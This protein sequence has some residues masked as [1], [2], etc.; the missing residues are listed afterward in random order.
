VT[1]T[2]IVLLAAAIFLVAAPASAAESDRL[3]DFQQTVDEVLRSYYEAGAG[4][5]FTESSRLAYG[6][7][8]TFAYYGTDDILSNTRL[9]GEIDAKFWLHAEA[10]GHEFYGR[11]R[12][13]Y[14]NF[15]EDDPLP[16]QKD[17]FTDPIFDRYWY[18]FDYRRDERAESG[19][20]PGW[21]WWVQAGRQYVEWLSGLALSDTLYA[22]RA[23][24]E[25]GSFTV[26]ALVALTPDS[27]VDFDGSRPGYDSDTSRFFWGFAAECR[28]LRR[29]R[30]Y[31]YFLAQDDHNDQPFPP[32]GPEYFYES[33]YVGVG[34]TGEIVT[35]TWLYRVE[36]VYEFGESIANLLGP[37][38]QPNDDIRAWAGRFYVAYMPAR[39]RET[40]GL[41]VEAEVLLG[42]GDDD[43]GAATT[44]AGGNTAGTS[45]R[46]F[47]AFGYV[48]TG[49][50]LA[51]ELANLIS[52]RVTGSAFPLRGRGAFDKMRVWISGFVFAKQDDGAPVSVATLP[53]EGYLGSEIDIGV[54]WILANDVALNLQYGIFL[55]GDAFADS[56][57]L[58]FFYV[59]ISY[60]F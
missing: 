40:L 38:P 10:R 15:D 3:R 22:A 1:V 33:R 45:D 5:T 37:L 9:F 56:D 31:V 44:T 48:N 29:H 51:P 28:A 25:R 19:F 24:L 35:G 54:D 8:T 34:S 23:G 41:R 47:I 39:A 13:L 7:Y 26:Q 20:D 58:H 32:G 14:D 17:G 57:A 46:S 4:R 50:V 49:L 60:G 53:G 43:R 12:L 30:P 55:P 2:R 59:G 52:V 11:A 18:R 36:L 27:F 42:S 6:A 21:N 16:G